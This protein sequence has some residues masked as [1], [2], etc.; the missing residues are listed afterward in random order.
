[1]VTQQKV[2]SELRKAGHTAAKW[3]PS[4]MVRGWGDWTPGVRV[5]KRVDRLLVSYEAGHNGARSA[6][7][8]VMEHYIAPT[9]RAAG[10]EG[11]LSD[12]KLT[13]IISLT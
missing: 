8:N 9:L 11:Q 4:R 10:I 7:A 12:D 13:Y 5:V 6:E 1:M 2:Y 3:E